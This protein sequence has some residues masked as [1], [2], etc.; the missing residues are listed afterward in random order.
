M[1]IEHIQQWILILVET[2]VIIFAVREVRV[3]AR[4]R[5]SSPS[6]ATAHAPGAVHG[7]HTFRGVVLTLLLISGLFLLILNTVNPKVLR[8]LW[9]NIALVGAGIWCTISV[10]FFAILF[11]SLIGAIV[12]VIIAIPKRNPFLFLIDYGLLSVIYILLGIP[13]IVFL[14]ICYY[15]PT[16]SLPIFWA[17]VVALSINLAPFVAKIVLASLRNISEEQKASAIA[18][19]YNRWQRFW[20]FEVLFVI[21]N[22]G[23][24][25]LVEYYT[26]IKL[27]SLASIF[28]L[29][30]TYHAAADIIAQTYDPVSAYIIMAIAYVSIVTW[31]AILADY[32]AQKWQPQPATN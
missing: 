14:F 16:R 17:S 20:F 3:Q 4:K 15:G 8:V 32:L 24:A 28:A 25:L 18:F 2:V 1:S 30:E 31:I 19:G 26:T 10:S 22:A 7:L 21:K 9:N 29:Y 13:A 6:K 27:S 11:G 23:Q 12:A 5:Q